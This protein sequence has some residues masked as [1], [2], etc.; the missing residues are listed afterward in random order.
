M[1][2][3]LQWETEAVLKQFNISIA[4]VDLRYVISYRVL[5]SS[6]KYFQCENMIIVIISHNIILS[7]FGCSVL[8]LYF[9]FSC[10]TFV[11]LKRYLIY[12]LC[13]KFFRFVIWPGNT[14]P[15]IYSLWPSRLCATW[16]NLAPLNLPLLSLKT[17]QSTEKI[18][19][20][21]FTCSW[22][23]ILNDGPLYC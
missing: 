17:R 20:G 5:R 16:A 18:K 10:I 11:M 19:Q 22:V 13:N 15:C 23:S 7:A 4:G 1:Y 21:L 3:P 2:R 6:L 8:A 9:V 14:S 12:I